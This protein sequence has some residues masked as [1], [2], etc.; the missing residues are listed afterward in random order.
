MK[1]LGAYILSISA[2]AMILGILQTLFDK[3]SCNA[4][5]LRLIGGLF[6]TFT[7][8]APAADINFDSVFD[9]H[10]DFLA[11]GDLI[12]AQGHEIAQGQRLDIIKENCE[13]YI[14]DKAMSYQTELCADV[15]LSQNAVPVPVAVHLSGNVSPYV[16]SAMQTWL[17]NEM[18]IPRENQIWT[19]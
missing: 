10:Q 15:T 1:E 3:K 11:Q 14:L 7:I 12:S 6:L 13:A 4:Q 17:S 8:I 5:L 18:G 16:K 9:I 19:G 2:A